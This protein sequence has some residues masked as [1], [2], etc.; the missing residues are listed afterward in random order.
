MRH[1]EVRRGTYRD[2]VQLLQVS[3]A[4]SG[5]PG[6]TGAMVAM[7]TELNLE[8][9]AGMG[10]EPPADATAGDMV[11][12]IATADEPTRDA[13]VAALESALAAKAPPATGDSTLPPPRTV[14]A[15][16]RAADANLALISTP[17][18]YAFADA[19]DALDAGAN[20]LV[21]SD[22]VPVEQEIALK[23]RAA[24]RGL[25]VMGPDCGTAVVGGLGLGFA[26]VVRPGPVGIVA[27]SG[28]GAQQVLTLLDAAGV[29]ISHCLG[30]GG[31][32]L[33]AAVAGRSTLAALDALGADP[34]TEVILVI[35]KPPAPAVADAVRE[36]AA[37][38][39]KPVVFG[40]LGGGRPDLTAVVTEVLGV[41]GKTAP[42][43]WP[44]WLPSDEGPD[45][46]APFSFG[47][48]NLRGIYSG[49]T[50]CDEAMVIASAA[51]GPIVSNIPLDPAWTI[52]AD[53]KADGHA[54][55]DFGD[56]ALTAGRP[57]PMID[58]T[59]R[60]ARL[61]S[62][63]ADPDTRV[64]L[65]DV[66]LGHGAHPDPA[67]ELAPAIAAAL[68]AADR[69]FDVVIALVGSAG[70]P[71]G[72]SRQATELQGVGARVFSSNA[73]AAREA[74]AILKPDEVTE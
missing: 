49:G 15:A 44:R 67:S 68:G 14:G 56:D 13:A 29:G 26:N 42:S 30:V 23:D 17:G 25:L 62:E 65:M 70:D 5:L 60:L 57:H 69:P 10:F 63:A 71:Q 74:V 47:T 50:L 36:H 8:L 12:A 31:R 39:S 38:L 34:A 2:S 9:I 22:N 28:T 52:G 11:V 72:A 16:V 6:V 33:S 37:G 35:S 61:A 46:V 1:V 18:R 58:G 19:M 4:V 43:P 32:D 55:L 66:V 21:F 64:V 41:L 7:G 73:E 45:L 24:E 20:V 59:L 53:L 3:Q 51:L 54:M 27:A 40:L 48:G